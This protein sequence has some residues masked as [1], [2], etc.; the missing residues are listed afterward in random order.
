MQRDEDTGQLVLLVPDHKRGVIGPA[1]IGIDGELEMF[2]KTYVETIRPRFG[3][4]SK[5][6]QVTTEGLP[7][8]KGT[9]CRRMPE[10][11]ERSGVRPDLRV[12]A[13]NIRK[14]IVTEC[15]YTK[16]KG[17]KFDEDIVRL[18]LCHSDKTAKSFYLRSDKT[19]VAA[20]SAH[21]IAL[22]TI[23]KAA[24]ASTNEQLHYQSEKEKVSTCTSA[25]APAIESMVEDVETPESPNCSSPKAPAIES[26]VEDVETPESPI[27]CS[28]KGPSTESMIE[29]VE[30][31]ESPKINMS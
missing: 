18:G 15:H 28:L 30:M 29:V 1:L 17:A 4:K 21:I 10:L 31:L 11:W 23:R 9:I 14:W 20:Q 25:K 7:F 22:C 12:A 19:C 26:R 16:T 2:Y 6:L 24:A 27:C 5:N 3:N 8:K 13:T